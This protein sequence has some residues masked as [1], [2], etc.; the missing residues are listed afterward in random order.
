MLAR[1]IGLCIAFGCVAFCAAMDGTAV[2][3]APTE[4]ASR[5]RSVDLRLDQAT[6]VDGLSLTWI[7]IADSRCPEGVMCVWAGEVTVTLAVR[8]GGDTREIAL[9][10][11]PLEG[12]SVKTA[13]HELRLDDVSPY[14][15]QGTHVNRPAYRA[16]V[17]VTRL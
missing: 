12:G 10:L 9:T 17:I 11:R 6:D 15:G 7:S 1:L 8:E 2:A 4:T 14:P 5:K 13:H 16:T 3:P